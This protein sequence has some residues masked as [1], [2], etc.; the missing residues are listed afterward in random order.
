[1]TDGR[2]RV[3]TRAEH[4][5]AK[6]TECEEKAAAAKDSE[7]KRMFLEAATHWREMAAQAE[8]LGR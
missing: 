4:F 3:S 5:R 1:L 2:N 6:A 7:A 8:W